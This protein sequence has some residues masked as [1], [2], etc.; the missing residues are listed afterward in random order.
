MSMRDFE[1]KKPRFTASRGIAEVRYNRQGKP[2]K[3]QKHRPG[4][5]KQAT[6]EE[7]KCDQH[8][9]GWTSI[10]PHSEAQMLADIYR[11]RNNLTWEFSEEQVLDILGNRAVKF[12]FPAGQ[13][14]F[15]NLDGN[16]HHLVPV[17]RD[18]VFFHR[19]AGRPDQTRRMDYDQFH[20]EFNAS[21]HV[22]RVIKEKGN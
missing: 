10:V 13:T 19:P 22:A 9:N 14:C 18:P 4:F 17:Q 6:C 16:G 5:W 8:L 7:A 12:V 1:H 15:R 20:E 3:T 2:I 11:M 21:I